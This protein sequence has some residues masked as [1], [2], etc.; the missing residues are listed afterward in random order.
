MLTLLALLAPLALADTITLESGAAVEGEIAWYDYEGD[1]Q[2]AVTD[3]GLQGT[4]IVVPC[5]RIIRFERDPADFTPMSQAA[6]VEDAPLALA[7]PDAEEIAAPVAED[8][9]P[10]VMAVDVEG[11]EVDDGVRIDP[12]LAPDDELAAGPDG[13]VPSPERSPT[14]REPAPDTSATLMW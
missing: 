9:G 6:V 13:R 7:A 8:Q 5:H 1:C 4:I 12:A 10:D 3:G 2:I 14:I 11:L